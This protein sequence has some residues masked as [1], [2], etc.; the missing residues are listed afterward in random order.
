[1]KDHDFDVAII[2]MAGRFPGAENIGVF[3]DNLIA[4][5]ESIQDL[6]EE[7]LE[8]EG[9]AASV[10]NNEAY[11]KRAP[12][13]KDYDKF[14]AGFFGYSP[15]EARMMDPQQRLFLECAWEALESAGYHTEEYE[16]P[17]SIYGGA[18]MN[19]YF[20]QS[21]MM[22]RFS[23][24]YLP[25]LL[26][27][28]N[29]F[30]TTRVS[31]KLN[32][33]GPSVTVQTAC[34]TGLIA[35]H[36]ACMSL[37]NHE[38]KMALAG[39][40]SVRA[41]HHTGYLHQEG[42]VFSRDGHC[43]PFDAKASGTIFGSGVGMVVLKRYADAVED[44]DHIY[45]VIKGSAINNDG[46]AKTDY[47]APSV[48][49]QAEVIVEALANAGVD[50]NTIS[51][52]EAHGTGTYLG[53]PIEL[54]ALTKAFRAFTE[55]KGFC[56]IGSVK[57]NV[58]HLDAAA[59]ITGLIKTAL[60]LHHKRIPASL[61]FE[62][63]NPE[64]DFENSPFYVAT[65]TTDWISNGHPR[66]A[67]ITSLGMGGT[68]A[69]VILEEY[70]PEIS[71]EHREP[72]P[73]LLNLSA[74]TE[75]AL[76]TMT[77]NLQTF[78]Q[79]HP[80]QNLED[81][82]YTLHKG[83]KRFSHRRCL[84]A[85]DTKEAA[86]LLKNHLSLKTWH[87][88]KSDEKIVFMFPGQG[89]QYVNMA[90]GLYE[91]EPV[92]RKNIDECASLISSYLEIDIRDLIYPGNSSNGNEAAE[93]LKNTKITQ[94]VL[95]AVEHALAQLWISW[96]IEPAA[97]IGHSS[98]EYTATCVAGVLSLEESIA[99]ITLRAKLMASVSGGSMLSIPLAADEVLPIIESRNVSLAVVNS[100]TACV[101]SGETS[102]IEAL[103]REFD[104]RNI[105]CRILQTSIAAHS[106]FM[107]PVLD[108][109]REA[110]GRVSFSIPVIPVLSSTNGDWVQSDEISNPDYWVR[111]IREPVKFGEAIQKVSDR[112]LFT[113]LEVGPGRTLC[114]FVQQQLS[115]HKELVT[116]QSLRHPRQ[117]V[118]DQ[119][120]IYESLGSLWMAGADI[121][122][123]RFHGNRVGKKVPLPTYPFERK[124]YWLQ[125]DKYGEQIQS[126]IS[127][128]SDKKNPSKWLYRPVWQQSATHNLQKLPP[129]NEKWLVFE[130]RN[131]HG[132]ILAESCGIPKGK[133]MRV[134]PG[135]QF[136]KTAGSQYIINPEE[137]ADYTRLLNELHKQQMLP[138]RIIHLWSLYNKADA[139]LE[140]TFENNQKFNFY[141]L[142]Y[143][144]QSLAE[145]NINKEISI[146]IF[147]NGMHD[148]SGLEAQDLSS[149]TLFGIAKV[150]PIE[151]PNLSCHCIDLDFDH[152]GPLQ[153]TEAMR[154]ELSDLNTPDVVVWRG[155]NRWEKVFKQDDRVL[156]VTGVRNIK[157]GGIYLITGG[158]GEV[159]YLF[160]EHLA[161]NYNA[162]LIIAGRTELPDTGQWLH[163]SRENRQDDGAS[164]KV[165]KLLNLINLG[166]DVRYVRAN[167]GNKDELKKAFEEAETS[168]GTLDG[169]VHAAGD[170]S[171]KPIDQLT[172][173]DC[174]RYFQPKVYGTQ[175]IG[176]IISDKEP[177]FVLNISSVSSF[178]GGYGFA[179]YAASNSCLDLASQLQSPQTSTRIININWDAIE[180]STTTKWTKKELML[181]KEQVKTIFENILNSNFAGQII[182]SSVGNIKAR[183]DTSGAF[184]TTKSTVK[185]ED[186]LDDLSAENTEEQLIKGI[187]KEYLGLD[188]V[189]SHDDFFQLGGSSLAAVQIFNRIHQ[190]TGIKIPMAKIFDHSTIAKL[191]PLLQQEQMGGKREELEI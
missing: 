24:E 105:K 128:H 50:A 77:S 20:I 123:D 63:P 151:Y 165:A 136:K 90:K 100:K 82:A 72:R 14:D 147:T 53:D 142:L 67:G 66:R 38:S 42:S 185:N 56:A 135:K 12:V 61:Y 3:W 17:V 55:K 108:E 133:F 36:T 75:D 21:G 49:S 81:I 106:H 43:R 132:L 174:D 57:S 104:G 134:S 33:K 94:P 89:S 168:F 6:S 159:G 112:S 127:S 167:V 187:W 97:V 144:T 141:S 101:V 88:E 4:G 37:L 179:G 191:V 78:L 93:K 176:S 64:I 171:V 96:G 155:L 119:N 91:N 11:V 73:Q 30:L 161:K 65:Q 98:G 13:L 163:Y 115:D 83:R 177:D 10:Y 154:A 181:S 52:V 122:W 71:D 92:F 58:G 120:F 102:E 157:M 80:G 124:R 113:L 70:Q 60:S 190:E 34:S 178:L 103:E 25:T 51:Y 139:T 99:L 68:N 47:T 148:I 146:E 118:K 140:I 46:S 18:A 149:A 76:N 130:D 129:E 182:V 41:P 79:E 188:A 69:H 111:N 74:R 164:K 28:D 29:S 137:P 166:A 180:S 32:L 86:E 117:E 59:G 184:A 9:I 152:T 131:E 189:S 95:F 156:D 84:V 138:D 116:A 153:I 87:S 2:G 15:R 40:V 48:N 126:E 114:T 35:V 7:E 8:N 109:F 107:D 23:D 19:T 27:N 186:S 1:M 31:Y 160:A 16:Y 121:D 54:R 85:N 22:S 44:R 62:E 5:K 39:G 162:K 110:A 183:A 125:A 45:A 170:V 150:I 172:P 143:I 158:L 26:G 175:N 169:I 145:L 173:E